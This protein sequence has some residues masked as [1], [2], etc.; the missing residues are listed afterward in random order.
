[1]SIVVRGG[2]SLTGN[3]A[4]LTEGAAFTINYASDADRTFLVPS[5]AR[6]ITIRVY[7]AG[8]GAGGAG[9]G[10]PATNGANGAYN[11]LTNHVMGA[12]RLLT[13]RIGRGGGGGRGGHST[14]GGGGG[15]G[16]WPDGAVGGGSFSWRASGGGGGGS[17]SVFLGSTLLVR[18]SGGTG[19]EAATDHPEIVSG[20][21]GGAHPSGTL[22]MGAKGGAVSWNG[23][24]GQNGWLVIHALT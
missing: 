21:L 7:G 17:T 13:L 5:W 19:G 1:M 18:A 6:I 22:G 24:P 4:F 2:L 14:E 23:L 3:I 16:G 11:I 15:Y 20:G 10:T 9:T 12:N 8:G